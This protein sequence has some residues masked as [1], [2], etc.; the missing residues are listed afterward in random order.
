MDF[1]IN[2]HSYD[3]DIQY[4]RIPFK[5]LD[6]CPNKC[7]LT[8]LLKYKNMYGWNVV[9]DYLLAWFH[10]NLTR[11]S[12]EKL[13]D[14][15]VNEKNIYAGLW[16]FKNILCIG[17]LGDLV[18]EATPLPHGWEWIVAPNKPQMKI[19]KFR[20]TDENFYKIN[21]DDDDVGV[22]TTFVFYNNRNQK[23]CEIKEGES[24]APFREA[25]AEA[26]GLQADNKNVTKIINRSIKLSKKTFDRL[27]AFKI[28]GLD[29]NKM[30]VQKKTSGIKFIKQ[31][32]TTEEFWGM[33]LKKEGIPYKV[34]DIEDYKLF[35]TGFPR[36]FIPPKIENN[37][38][39]RVFSSIP[40]KY[41]TQAYDTWVIKSDL[42]K[43]Y[44]HMLELGKGRVLIECLGLEVD[45]TP[46][47]VSSTD[48]IQKFNYPKFIQT[49]SSDKNNIKLSSTDDEKE[50]WEDLV[51]SSDDEEE[52]NNVN[53]KENYDPFKEERRLEEEKLKILQKDL[54]VFQ[55]ERLRLVTSAKE[56]LL[57]RNFSTLINNDSKVGHW[58]YWF[59]KHYYDEYP[60]ER[61]KGY[62]GYNKWLN[63]I[64]TQGGW[65]DK[66]LK[67][68]RQMGNERHSVTTFSIDEIIRTPPHQI[69]QIDSITTRK[70]ITACGSKEDVKKYFG[71]KWKQI[72]P[73]V[74]DK[75]RLINEEIK[76]TENDIEYTKGRIKNMLY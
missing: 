29:T 34:F 22:V 39:V 14:D 35:C 66:I 31:I 57:N 2:Y 30:Y 19:V 27:P 23:I 71:Y 48:N 47:K 73:V 53:K 41:D 62:D 75:I 21:D 61:G 38:W 76:T 45:D 65:R 46:E 5:F 8:C 51:L 68:V 72:K 49:M 12:M 70:L 67:K 63:I 59:L 64:P 15:L 37:D 36:P 10:E 9:D 42:K 33:Y 44:K 74:E 52:A 13:S 43:F 58:M 40:H 6:R 55:D 16:E 69:G 54:T 1:T 4:V 56:L 28:E 32:K 24:R 50:E 26:L 17:V 25:V 3:G 18:N 60:E 11:K 20:F 7:Y